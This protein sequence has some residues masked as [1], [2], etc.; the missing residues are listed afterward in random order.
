MKNILLSLVVGLTLFVLGVPVVHAETVECP[1]A[2]SIA[3]HYLHEQGIKAGS[4]TFKNI[5]SVISKQMGPQTD[6]NNEKAC[7]TEDYERI[8]EFNV[9]NSLNFEK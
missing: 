6:F 9:V 5:I 1:A 7:D 3:A 4:E 2:P 8:V